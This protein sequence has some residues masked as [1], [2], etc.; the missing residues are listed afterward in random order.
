MSKQ[1]FLRLLSFKTMSGKG[2]WLSKA[3]GSEYP[4]GQKQS[5]RQVTAWEEDFSLQVLFHRKTSLMTLL[6]REL[7]NCLAKSRASMGEERIAQVEDVLVQ[8]QDGYSWSFKSITRVP[9]GPT[10]TSATCSDFLPCTHPEKACRIRN[11]MNLPQSRDTL[12]WWSPI[13][14]SSVFHANVRK[15]G[16][17]FKKLKDKILA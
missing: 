17:C 2:G 13:W 9:Q 8:E 10:Q 16:L 11:R 7:H 1:Y 12:L 3:G 15:H 5:L 4:G 14:S 6:D